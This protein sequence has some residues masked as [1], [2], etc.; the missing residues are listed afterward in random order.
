[1]TLLVSWLVFPLLSVVLACGCG[2]LLERLAGDTV[3][4]SLLVPLGLAVVSVV[5]SFATMLDGT[6]EL[7]APAVVALAVVGVGLRRRGRPRSDRW[8][9]TCAAATFLAFG[10]PVLASGEATFAGYVTLD[11]TATFLA[12]LDHTLDTGRKLGGRSQS[13]Y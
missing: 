2:L 5:A 4:A 7:A 12:I 6:A 9:V 11:D 1:M 8:A 3:P 13:S 10:A